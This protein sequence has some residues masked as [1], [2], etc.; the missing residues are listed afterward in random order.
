[1]DQSKS[2]SFQGGE[3]SIQA[4][5][6]LGTGAV[7]TQTK[8]VG[9]IP[10][11]CVVTGVRYHGQAQVTATGLTAD[12][13]VRTA[14]GAAGSSVQSAA[15]SV[16]FA[17]AAAAKTGVAATMTTGAAVRPNENQLVEVVIT[18]DTCSAGPGD[19]LVEIAFAPRI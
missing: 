19:L 14:A 5:L 11:N 9:L 4:V 3:G 15:K 7:S 17:S 16:A 10:K 12:V 2:N 13:Y 8:I 1:M 18:A 6:S